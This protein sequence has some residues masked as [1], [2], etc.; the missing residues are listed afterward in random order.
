M[1]ESRKEGTTSW[2]SYDTSGD[3]KTLATDFSVMTL[4][5]AF[6]PEHAR[7]IMAIDSLEGVTPSSLA[8]MLKREEFSVRE[9]LSL[10][11]QSGLVAR[12]VDSGEYHLTEGGKTVVSLFSEMIKELTE[13]VKEELP[14]LIRTD[15]Q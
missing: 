15:E 2:R 8:N 1:P 11:V 3:P 9:Q 10:L 12:N 14:K 7:L 5:Q 13:I 6:R 4:S